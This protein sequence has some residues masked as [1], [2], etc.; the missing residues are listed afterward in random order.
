LDFNSVIRLFN[1]G[2]LVVPTY[3]FT[4]ISCDVQELKTSDELQFFHELVNRL[5]NQI[6]GFKVCGYLF[7][8]YIAES[9]V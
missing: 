2:L 3:F 4:F 6:R 7:V 1:L 5:N 9:Q 8:L